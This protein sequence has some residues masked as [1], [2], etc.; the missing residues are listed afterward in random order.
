[1]SIKTDIPVERNDYSVNFSV[2]SRNLHLGFVDI[3]RIA[4]RNLI[5]PGRP[6]EA[7]NLTET[8]IANGEAVDRSKAIRGYH[9][10]GH[11]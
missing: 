2:G 7:P 1:M 11:F 9:S 3:K 8:K 4:S 10:L 5:P 6:L